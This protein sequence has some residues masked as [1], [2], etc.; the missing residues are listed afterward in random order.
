LLAALVRLLILLHPIYGPRIM[1]PEH[2]RGLVDRLARNTHESWMQQRLSEGWR[3]GEHR[4]DAT[5]QH[6]CLVP[7]DELPESE[8]SYDVVIT[9]GLLKSILAFGCKIEVPQVISGS[10]SP[11]ASPPTV[12][13]LPAPPVDNSDPRGSGQDSESA[14]LLNQGLRWC[15]E[16]VEPQYAACDRAALRHQRFHRYLTLIAG[17]AGT[18]AVLM[19]IFQLSKLGPDTWP[20]ELEF[21]AAAIALLAVGAGLMAKSQRHWLLQR[22]KAERLQMLKYQFLISPALW[23]TSPQ[24]SAPLLDQLRDQVRQVLNTT[25]HDMELWLADCAGDADARRQPSPTDMPNTIVDYYV[26]ERLA[27]QLVYATN[28][29]RS[30]ASLERSTLLVGPSFFLISVLAAFGHFA[31]EVINKS[32][33]RPEVI[34]LILIFVAAALPAVG[35]G[36]RILRGAYEFARNYSRFHSVATGL[37]QISERLR[38]GADSSVT[39]VLLEQSERV[40][41]AEHR[42]WL[43]LMMEAE[44]FG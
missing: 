9:E 4:D 21:G 23:R 32:H 3:Y 11:I 22:H 8:R 12:A 24:N 17:V 38:Q 35:A 13:G 41:A 36:V 2:L 37:S 20:A 14:G 43:R 5:K 27:P 33:N 31:Y 16:I 39:P 40:L 18:L 26:R 7:Y 30:N 19:A 10:L 25:K 6:P 29:A 28:R 42:E 1:L 44:W 34:G 15:Q